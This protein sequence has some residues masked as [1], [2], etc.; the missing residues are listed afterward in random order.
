MK[1]TATDA[2]VT[3][4]AEI[5]SRLDELKSYAENHMGVNSEAINW[6]HVG[7]AERL[8]TALTELTD[9]AYQRGEYA[10]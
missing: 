10:R 4:L 9:R 1:K 7:S 6:G 2:F 8:L 3:A 5:N